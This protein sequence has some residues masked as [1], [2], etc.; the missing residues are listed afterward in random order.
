M[1]TERATCPG[2]TLPDF[3]RR[4]TGWVVPFAV[5]AICAALAVFG[6]ALTA[7]TGHVAPIWPMNAFVV[8][9]MIRQ[10]RGTWPWLAAAAALGGLVG[11]LYM[12][13]SW[14]T[15]AA[16]S[17]TNVFEILACAV[18]FRH[19]AGERSG[20]A[21][22]RPLLLFLG[23]AV[24][25]PALS[26]LMAAIVLT[27]LHVAPFYEVFR[28]WYAADVL[29]LLVFAPALLAVDWRKLGRLAQAESR[30]ASLMILPAL[31]LLVLAVFTQSSYPFLFMLAPALIFIA[32]RLGLGGTALGLL[33]TAAIAIALTVSGHGPTQL[34]SGTEMG[35]ILVLQAFLALTSLSTLPIAAAVTQNARVRA[36]L[37]DALRELEVKANRS[38]TQDAKHR[39]DDIALGQFADEPSATPPVL[40]ALPKIAAAATVGLGLIVLLGWLFGI[41]A[42][43]SVL[44]DL[45]TMKPITAV[46]FILSGILLYLSAHDFRSHN[47]RRAQTILATLTV[48]IG[49]FTLIGFAFLTDFNIGR[50]LIAGGWSAEA[51]KPMSL[52]TAM[53]FTVFGTAMLLPKR[54]LGDLAFVTLTFVGI[55]LSLLVFAGYLYNLPLLYEPV[56]ANSIALHTAVTFFVLFV[57]AA[58]TRPYTG[59]VALL[60]PDSVTGA[61]APWLLPAIV[62]LPIALGWG[63]NQV[64]RSSLITAELGVDIFALASVFFLTVVAWRTGVI[65]NRLGRHL[66]LREQLEARLREARTSAEEAT[67]AKSDFLA[68]MTH[69]LR[70]PL[71][72]IIGFAGLLAKGSGL[73]SKDRRYVEIIDGS[74]QSLLALVNDIL[75]LSSLESGSVV[76]HPAPFSLPQLVER[77]AASFSLISQEKDLTLKIEKGNAVAPGHFGDE[78]RIRQVLVNLVNNAVKFTSKGGM[79]I[80]LSA[81]EPSDSMQHLRIEVRD[82][83]IGIAPDKLKVLFGRFSQADA[84][85]HSRFGGTGLGLAISK[86]L[87]ELMGGT[88]G[89]ESVE[90]KGTTLWLTLSLP[91]VDPAASVHKLPAKGPAPQSG[92]RHILVVDDVDLNR[93]LVASLLTPFGYIVHQAT[94]GAE[95][96]TAVASTDYDL[97]LMD[98]QMPG[99]DGLTATRAIREVERLTKLPIVAMTAQALPNQITACHEA[100]M[101]DYLA[102]PITSA[103]LLAAIEKW[104]G[105]RSSPPKAAPEADREMTELRGEFVAQCAQD[106]ARIKLLL[107]S[108]SPGAREELKRLVH[109]MAGTAGMLGLANLSVDTSELN[110]LLAR[111]DRLERANYIPFV[112]KLETSLRAA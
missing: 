8:A 91:C 73:K 42:L 41:E 4:R 92:G 34:I 100:G 108:G 60:S 10:D 111:G 32:F 24:T 99:M 68:N 1:I 102:K 25:V 20:I 40:A 105:D 69:E 67:T 45:A 96:M 21:E 35:R 79:T 58:M 50:F 88:I 11:N 59:W 94:D 9:L 77:V 87:I 56:V 112:E 110:K 104:A 106:L 7:D 23:V 39:P 3:R 5:A 14:P 103:A 44:P 61:F 26:A 86:R 90:G 47:Y 74:S 72:S 52:I 16:L 101:N 19:L 29:G 66:E 71:N 43:R 65:A 37:E 82:T 57:G 93:E 109:R 84:S 12:D 13:R 107:A 49:A 18:M 22:P 63:L 62:V 51:A 95:A 31:C 17:G 97:V 81:E 80:A 76:L 30:A 28:Y 2:G 6:I 15:A 83:G 46:T 98:V 78:M 54:R 64:I 33:L 75:D 38:L 89:V 36:G 27:I 85:I 53:E 48:A 55:L 70:T